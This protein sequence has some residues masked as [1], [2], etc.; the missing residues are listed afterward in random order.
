[1]CS[2]FV[3]V[4]EGEPSQV[5]DPGTADGP[6]EQLRQ[7]PV[8]SQGCHVEVTRGHRRSREGAPIVVAHVVK[9]F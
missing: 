6:L 9:R 1:M 3:T 4:G 8:L 2:V 7:L 5:W